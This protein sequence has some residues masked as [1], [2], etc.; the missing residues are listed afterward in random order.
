VSAT[1]VVSAPA[2]AASVGE[3]AVGPRP[4]APTGE[5]ERQ[6]IADWRKQW[7]AELP[8]HHPARAALSTSASR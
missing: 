2:R 1:A 6:I 4:G 8:A 5:V 3:W 7:L